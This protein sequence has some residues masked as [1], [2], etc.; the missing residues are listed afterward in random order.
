MKHAAEKTPAGQAFLLCEPSAA[1]LLG[2]TDLFYGGVACRLRQSVQP[3][4]RQL[5]AG[6]RVREKSRDN[7]PAYQVY[8]A[9]VPPRQLIRTNEAH[10]GNQY[11]FIPEIEDKE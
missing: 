1:L 6:C 8:M 11:L 2:P 3:E 10:E 7:Q 9:L 5:V 4:S